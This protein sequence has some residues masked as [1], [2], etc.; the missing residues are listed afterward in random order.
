MHPT[1]NPI[2]VE[3]IILLTNWLALAHVY[4]VCGAKCT[5]TNYKTYNYETK[6]SFR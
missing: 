5:Y 6:Y 2:N 4:L 3:N 1:K